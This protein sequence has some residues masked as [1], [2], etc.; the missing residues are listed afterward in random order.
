MVSRQSSAVIKALQEGLGGIRDILLDGSQETFCKIFQKADF[1][2]RK[3]QSNNLIMAQSPRFLMES[4][5]IVIIAA[6]SIFIVTE[7][8]DIAEAI[9]VLGA[10]AMGAQ[11]LLPL[12]QLIYA[13][14][15]LIQGSYRS[16]EDTLDLLDQPLPK[17]IDKHKGSLV[18][19][20]SLRLDAISFGYLKK[21]L[22]LKNIS[23]EI[24]KGSRVGFIG[25]TGSGKSTLLDVV[26]GFL[27][28][29]SGRL[30]VDNKVI[31]DRN[32]RAWQSHVAHVPQ[33]IFLSD[34]SIAENI[35]FG[36]A[37]QDIDYELVAEAASCAQ[38]G[39][40]INQLPD[41]YKTSVGERG[42]RL[43]GGQRQRIGIARAL[44]K[45]PD[46]L[47]FDEA[48]SALDS[49]TEKLV[50]NTIQQ[51][52]NEITVLIIAHRLSTLKVCNKIVELSEG[53]VSRVG[54]FNEI[55]VSD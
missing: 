55:V 39:D 43:S 10:L 16:I 29:Q 32:R 40:F 2:L 27:L 34:A 23:M 11:R 52:S 1:A 22:I 18:F 12:M 36:V 41:G 13:S 44:Y 25:L 37:T 6:I 5:G 28:P 46:V 8:G 7:R 17:Y 3:A 42:V 48:T 14:W 9:P 53:K 21:E 20:K 24:V 45:Q 26:M 47:I 15:S 33:S 35:A 31:N 30:L 54:T 38:L 4:F 49:K 19:K 50:M 51:L